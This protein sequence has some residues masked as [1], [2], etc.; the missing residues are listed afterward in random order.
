MNFLGIVIGAV[1]GAG[2][3]HFLIKKQG[4]SSQVQ[5]QALQNE[6]TKLRREYDALAKQKKEVEQSLDQAEQDIRS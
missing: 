2:G 5:L 4:D 1:V 6:I 3:Y